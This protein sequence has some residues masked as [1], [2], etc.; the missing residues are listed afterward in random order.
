MTEPDANSARYHGQEHE[1]RSW[2]KWVDGFIECVGSFEICS[3]EIYGEQYSGSSAKPMTY[4]FDD[5]GH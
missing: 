4:R 5:F 1:V 2:S 3:Q